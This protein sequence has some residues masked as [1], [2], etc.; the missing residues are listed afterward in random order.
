MSNT[1]PTGLQGQDGLQGRLGPT[2]IAGPVGLT[3]WG[4]GTTPGPAGPI[5]FNL[6]DV[7]SGTSITVTTAS[8]GTTYY[9][10]SPTIATITLP[11]SMTGITSGA[12]WVFNNNCATGLYPRLV[13]GTATYRGNSTASDI[14]IPAGCSITLV[15]TGSLS[16]YIVF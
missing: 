10:R 14:L 5:S 13:N 8:L 4:N 9:I 1:G 15:Y 12:L 11:A 7:A 6:S 3:G 16:N 2:G